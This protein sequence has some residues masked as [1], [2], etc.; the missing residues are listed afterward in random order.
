[1]EE[2]LNNIEEED[3]GPP[4]GF[5][6]LALPSQHTTNDETDEDEGPPPGWPSNPQQQNQQL[7][8][9]SLMINY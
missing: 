5:D 8:L 3:E 1:M 9:V 2:N 7:L 6:S 4:P